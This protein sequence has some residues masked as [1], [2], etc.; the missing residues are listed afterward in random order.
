MR[1]R[2]ETIVSAGH[3]NGPVHIAASY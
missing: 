1:T 2:A 3:F